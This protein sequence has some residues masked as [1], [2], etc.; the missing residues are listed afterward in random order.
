M[1]T[2]NE[3]NIICGPVLSGKQK[4]LTITKI[5]DKSNKL[6]NAKVLDFCSLDGISLH[7]N[8]ILITYHYI[9]R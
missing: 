5:F 8:I 1:M 9:L 4:F 3:N 6:A 2:C 7:M